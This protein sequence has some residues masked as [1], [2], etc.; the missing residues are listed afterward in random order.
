MQRIYKSFRL[1]WIHIRLNTDLPI[2][3][4]NPI[5]KY[6]I[7]V[8]VCVC[9]SVFLFINVMEKV[10]KR[11]RDINEEGGTH[12]MRFPEGRGERE[13]DFPRGGEVGG[14]SLKGG[15]TTRAKLRVLTLLVLLY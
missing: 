4:S 11:G 13:G 12:L 3:N 8:R 14:V 6:R 9:V 10:I 5:K 15:G 7:C 1:V 2:V